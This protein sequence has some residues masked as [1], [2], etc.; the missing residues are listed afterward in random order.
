VD[1]YSSDPNGSSMD[2]DSRPN[3][4]SLDLDERSA[5]QDWSSADS[6]SSCK[7]TQVVRYKIG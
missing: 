4:S 7:I 3:R 6:E 5:A 1:R 2:S